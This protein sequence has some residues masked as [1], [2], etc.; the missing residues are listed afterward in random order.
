[1]LAAAWQI[2]GSLMQRANKKQRE[3]RLRELAAQRE[4]SVLRSG[5]P[6]PP[7]ARP[8]EDLAAR[9]RAQ[10]EELRQRRAG[11]Q[12]PQQPRGLSAGGPATIAPPGLPSAHASQSGQAAPLPIPPQLRRPPGPVV[13]RQ[14]RPAQQQIPRPGQPIPRPP[15]R[16]Q[17]QARPTAAPVTTRPRPQMPA[18]HD[19]DPRLETVEPPRARVAPAAAKK[20]PEPAAGRLARV[21]RQDLTPQTLRRL[22][23]LREILDPPVSMRDQEVWQRM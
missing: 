15:S 5:A 22:I 6:M 10:L 3:Q 8:A 12:Q 19:E 21:S 23:V 7:P 2:V 13:A 1:M 17:P 9:R 4:T 20:P 11:R 18:P 16:P 14:S